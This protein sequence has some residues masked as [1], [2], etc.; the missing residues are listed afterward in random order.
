[1]TTL[2]AENAAQS[3][4][5][6]SM[7]WQQR[8]EQAERELAEARAREQRLREQLLLVL[9]AVLACETRH[10]ERGHAYLAVPA[11]SLHDPAAEMAALREALR[12]TGGEAGGGERR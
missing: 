12:P 3:D 10:D 7:R 5:E 6:T 11:R 4:R 2:L 9:D 8:A 1:M